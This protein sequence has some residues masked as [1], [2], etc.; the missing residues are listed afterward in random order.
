MLRDYQ[1]QALAA[2]REAR[3]ASPDV[4]RLAIE[5]ATGLGKT[6]TFAAELDEWLDRT[7]PSLGESETPRAL[8]LVHTDELIRQAVAK[9][10]FVTKGR[11]TIGV[12][13]A[14]RNEVDADIVVASVQT[15]IQPGRKE[16]IRDVGKIIVDEAHHAAAASYRAI[17]DWYG[18]APLDGKSYHPWIKPISLTGYSATLSRTDGQGLGHVFQD[19]AFSRSLSWGIRHGYL[20]DFTPWTIKIPGLDTSGSD[21]ALDASLA[22]SIAPE[23]VVQAWLEK[24]R[25][26][27]QECLDATDIVSSDMGYP[28]APA[29][30]PNEGCGTM[31]TPPSTVLFAP[32]VRSAEAFASAFNQAGIKAEVVAG[33]YSDEHNRAVLAR[34]E[35][36]VTTVVC[37]AMKLTEGFD[38]PRTMCVVVARPTQSVNL[39]IQMLGRCL[40]PWLDASAPPREQQHATL[41]SVQGTVQDVR[42]VA[43]LSTKIGT[44]RDG[45]SFLAM[46]DEWDLGKDIEPDAVQ[47]A[48]PVRVEQWD[49]MVQASSKAWKYTAGG[50]P[51]LPTRK[52]SEGYVFIVQ[53]G[54]EWQVWSRFLMGT[55]A[56]TIVRKI[57][58]APDLELAMAAAED[59]CQE[60][61]GDIGALLADKTRPWRKGMP[62]A[63]MQGHAQRL[64]LGKELLSIM[65]S[66]AGGKAGKLSDLISKV[67]ASKALDHNAQK[68]RERARA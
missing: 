18:A 47:Y 60:Y 32:L 34:H 55:A 28:V 4:T 46:E 64:G 19:L 7:R 20:L 15:L 9:I 17:L 49:A 33:A 52:R 23:A 11:W 8:V 29:Y 58:T 42:N 59:Y 13:K 1:T 68:I 45:V 62:S 38:S 40:R 44:A 12:V 3:E 63:D 50:I 2:L 10:K 25:G 21:A 36:G 53:A 16:Q 5:M 67:E 31:A 41:L 30:C 57:D 48:G 56:K 6:I 54:Q 22:E 51:F 14:G 24:T 37:N 26:M 66:R 35:A 27:C 39:L 43:D 65:E 61:G